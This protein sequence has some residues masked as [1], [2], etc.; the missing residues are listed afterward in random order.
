M[1]RIARRDA[2]RAGAG[3]AAMLAVG[4]PQAAAGRL[5]RD[6]ARFVLAATAGAR[7][8]RSVA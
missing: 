4:L 7:I 3:G 6:V 1:T 8:P 2:L 5:G